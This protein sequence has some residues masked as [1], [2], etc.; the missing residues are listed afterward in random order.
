MLTGNKK[1]AKLGSYIGIAGGIGSIAASMANSASSAASAAGAAGSDA[2]MIARAGE[3]GASANAATV[4]AQDAALAGAKAAAEGGG[5][6][7]AGVGGAAVDASAG[8]GLQLSNAGMDGAA[9]ALNEGSGS[10]LNIGAESGVPRLL[11]RPAEEAVSGGLQSLGADSS[12]LI[13]DASRLKELS[14]GYGDASPAWDLPGSAAGSDAG[15]LANNAK[16]I[17][18]MDHLQSLLDKVR[19]GAGSAFNGVTGFV[20]DNKELV[21]MVGK[22]IEAVN[23]PRREAMQFQV[24]LMEQRRRNLNS[25]VRMGV[26]PGAPLE[27]NVAPRG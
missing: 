21:S 9:G 19:S 15:L 13:Q 3:A 24:N 11:A 7:L 27:L 14:A 8:A 26:N 16:E 2:G 22:G 6:G 4:A 5:A 18:S 1:L 10:V 23:D 25:P 12:S 20:K 17:S